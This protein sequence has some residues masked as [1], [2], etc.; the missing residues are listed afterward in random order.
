MLRSLNRSA[1]ARV[2]ALVIGSLAIDACTLDTDVTAPGAMV[3]YAGDGQTQPVNTELPTPLAVIVVNQFGER[4]KNATVTWSIQSGGGSLSA[5][6]TLTDEA[7]LASVT[8]TTG[9][10]PGAAIINA[11]VHGLLPLSFTVT[12]T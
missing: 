7:G 11:Q 9:P 2:A 3:K 4:I 12:I 1:A 10:T 5:T 8:Y 6:S